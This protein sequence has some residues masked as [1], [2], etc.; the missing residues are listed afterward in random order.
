MAKQ[1]DSTNLVGLLQEVFN[2]VKNAFWAKGDTSQLS[3]DN[4][5]E[6]VWWHS[7][8]RPRQRGHPHRPDHLHG[9]RDG[10][11]EQHQ[12]RVAKGRLR[13]G[14]SLRGILTTAGRISPQ[15]ALQPRDSHWFRDLRPRH[16][17]RQYH[18][19]PLLLDLRGGFHR[20]D[21]HLARRRHLAWW[22][23]PGDLRRQAL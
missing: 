11:G 14:A 17:S 5:P 10:Q 9:H 20:P 3:I 18:S 8:E 23:R 6:A 19:Q 22:F 16:A 1:V 15:C 2:T 7:C 13:R 12:D 4:A 21:N